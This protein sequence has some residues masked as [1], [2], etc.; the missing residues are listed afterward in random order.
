MKLFG[1]I[2]ELVSAVFRKNSQTITL[3]P[4]Q[5]T[6]YTAARDVQL[7]EQDAASVLVSRT[8]T[9]TLTNKT[10]TSPVINTPTGITK[11]DVGL[12]NVDNTS[13]AT[14]NAASVTLTNKTL[15]SPVINTAAI[16]G[17]TVDGAVI[18]GVTPAAA[19]VTALVA[20]SGTVGGAAITTATNSQTLTNKTLTAPVISG[21]T[22]DN[23]VIG[24]STPAAA[25]VTALAATTATV[26]GVAVTTASNSQTLTNKTLTAPIISNYEELAE[27]SAPSTP[28]SGFGRLFASTDGKLKFLND[29]GLTKTLGDSGTGE[30]NA[31]LNP[32]DTAAGWSAGT[33]HTVAT[34]SS[35]SPLDPVVPTAIRVSATANAVESSTSGGAYAISTFPT[36][37]RQRKMKVQFAVISPSADTWKVS[38]YSGSTRMA[39]STDS[40]SATTITAGLTGSFTTTFDADASTSYSV[41]F[42][43]TAGT[44]TTNLDLTSLIVGPGIQPQGAV[45]SEWLTYTPT[46]NDQ[47]TANATYAGKYRRVGDSLEAFVQVLAGATTPTGGDVNATRISLPT[48]LTINTSII[49]SGANQSALGSWQGQIVGVGSFG[50]QVR[51]HTSNLQVELW[52]VKPDAGDY[53]SSYDAMS[54]SNITNGGAQAGQAYAHFIVPIA[55]WAGSGNLNVVQNDVEYASNSGMGDSTD[56]TSFVNGTGGSPLPGVAYSALRKKRV[57]FRTPISPTDKLEFQVDPTGSGQ[58]TPIGGGL[59]VGTG[60]AEVIAPFDPTVNAGDGTGLGFVLPVN[61]TDVDVYFARYRAATSAWNGTTDDAKWRVAKMTGGQAVGFGDASSTASGLVNTGTQTF[62]GQKQIN[63]SATTSTTVGLKL[64][65][66]N[67]AGNGNLLAWSDTWSVDGGGTRGAIVSDVPASN[68]GRIKFLTQTA[69]A[70]LTHQATLNSDGSWFFG[71][72]SPTTTTQMKGNISAANQTVMS[73]WLANGSSTAVAA[74]NIAKQSNNTTTGQSFI[75]FEVNRSTSVIG[76]GSGSGQINANGA[77]AAAFGSFSDIRM[78]ENIENLPAQLGNILALRPVEFDYIGVEDGHQIGFI[79]QEMQAIYPDAISERADGMLM[80]TGWDKTSAR[81]VKAIQEL[82]A[83]LESAKARIATLEGA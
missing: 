46:G 80:L 38:V 75:Q 71:E 52:R 16:S 9:D 57:R 55:E 15:T 24:G 36:A 64:H 65:D 68:T 60:G 3:R 66:T 18:G 13:D 11:S 42:T 28:A 6:T 23:A 19:T 35:G 50:G 20:T 4:N 34:I 76:S 63:I 5:T 41:R 83:E 33:S 81:L 29:D 30:I 54:A 14:K 21:G 77:N 48:G 72:Q 27:S 40:S 49:N 25:T 69:A 44:G 31:V 61:S 47:W 43:R 45:V 73:L 17:G 56:T 79:A 78:K 53:K 26:G 59:A 32:S 10:L 1:S 51:K 82:S 39:L 2:T 58:F 22:I 62:A 37:L 70:T 8:S 12:G 67:T 7:P 74:L